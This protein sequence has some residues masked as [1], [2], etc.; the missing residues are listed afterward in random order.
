[1]PLGFDMKY[2][3]YSERNDDITQRPLKLLYAGTLTQ[4]KGLSYL[5]NVVKRLGRKDITLTCIGGLQGSGAGLKGFESYFQ[6]IPAVSQAVM[7][8]KYQEYDALVLPTVFEGFGL[9]IVEAMAAG[10]PVITTPQSIGPEI[11]ENDVNGYIVPI[12]DEDALQQAI[13]KLR[14]KDKMA[15]LDMRQ[16]ARSRVMDYTW[17]A[18]SERLPALL[19]D[20]NNLISK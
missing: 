7:F 3:P 5:L 9:V 1:V 4:R 12:R 15:Y 8:Q 19:T 20:F 13:T 16:A 6:H 2:V 17:D 18:Y 14:N 10:L 11:I